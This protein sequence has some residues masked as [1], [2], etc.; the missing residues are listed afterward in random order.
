MTTP[1][2]VTLTLDPDAVELAARLAKAMTADP[3]A[4]AR[5]DLDAG[6]ECTVQD[7]V[8]YAFFRGVDALARQYLTK[9]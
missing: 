6:Q 2:Q 9:G 3:D 8:G 5:F 4:S 7:V 1:Q